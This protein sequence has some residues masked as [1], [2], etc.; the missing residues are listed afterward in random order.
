M[1][2]LILHRNVYPYGVRI[3]PIFRSLIMITSL[4]CLVLPPTQHCPACIFLL[5]H[6]G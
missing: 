1:T 6:F 2:T 3:P 4:N 5:P